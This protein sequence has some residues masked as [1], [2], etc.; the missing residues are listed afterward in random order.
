MTLIEKTRKLL[1][2]LQNSLAD[3]ME[4]LLE[5]GV[6]L[7]QGGIRIDEISRYIRLIYQ[8]DFE[9]FFNFK[10]VDQFGNPR[11]PNRG[12]P[13]GGLGPLDLEVPI[14]DLFVLDRTYPPY[15]PQMPTAGMWGR[16]V[17]G[18]G[19]APDLFNPIIVQLDFKDVDVILTELHPEPVAEN[20]GTA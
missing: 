12:K 15:V 20:G 10:D 11:V 14:M 6:M 9:F 17:G 18:A 7:P 13:A 1:S 8:N 5:K 2:S 3:C 4:A 16:W 19:Y